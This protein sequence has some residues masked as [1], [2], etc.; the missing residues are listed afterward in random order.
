MTASERLQ[1]INHISLQVSA[2]LDKGIYPLAFITNEPA[3]QESGLFLCV[4]Y[5]PEMM[6]LINVTIKGIA[7]NGLVISELIPLPK[8][9]P[10]N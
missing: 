5:S 9:Q 4:D 1:I 7:D 2:L 10:N 6:N 8:T 3:K